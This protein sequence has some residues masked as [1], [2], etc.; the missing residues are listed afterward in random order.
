MR[1]WM[2]LSSCLLATGLIA[3]GGANGDRHSEGTQEVKQADD[4]N[5][6]LIQGALRGDI[7]TIESALAS[8]ADVNGARTGEGGSAL[9]VAAARDHV[10]IV[11][12]LLNA[13]SDVNAKNR[14]GATAL[15]AGSEKEIG[16]ASC[17]ER[18]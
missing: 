8:G 11:R 16:R 3:C 5:R 14:L 7:G 18:V 9:M 1:Y 10:E 4:P 17:R 15:L 2:C 13:G 6:L 12:I